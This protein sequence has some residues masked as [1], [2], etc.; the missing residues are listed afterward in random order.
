MDQ[1]QSWGTYGQTR[2]LAIDKEDGESIGCQPVSSRRGCPKTGPRYPGDD[3]GGQEEPRGC[4]P[5]KYMD[6]DVHKSE[7][8]TYHLPI[9]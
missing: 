7:V 4:L 2:L 8:S 9:E 3:K 5:N 1:S 6:G